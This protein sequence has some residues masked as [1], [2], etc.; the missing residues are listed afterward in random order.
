MKNLKNLA[1]I[2]PINLFKDNYSYLITHNSQNQGILIDP[3]DPEKIIEFLEDFKT[4]KISHVLYTHKHWDHSGQSLKM[5]NFL[6]KR[7]KNEKIFFVS[8]LIDSEEI[9]FVNLKLEG[10]QGELKVS[11][12]FEIFYRLLPCHTKGHLMFNFKLFKYFGESGD[13]KESGFLAESESLKQSGNK[14]NSEKINNFGENKKQERILEEFNDFKN[15]QNILKDGNKVFFESN[16]FVFTG[17][18]LF[19]AGC[20]RFF[21]GDAKMMKNNFDEI[22]KLKND[23]LVFCGHEYTLNDLK[24]SKKIWGENNSYVNNFIDKLEKMESP[25]SIPSSVFLQKKINLFM[26]CHSED[27][28]KKFNTE[29]P[30]VVMKELRERKNKGVGI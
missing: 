1:R 16:N 24:W 28:K 8:S 29:D 14:G 2:Y 17:D 18:C 25:F 23:T 22:L 10:D 15:P 12:G 26:N 3:A 6:K 30:V 5:K 21:E 9:D 11:D 20:G 7:D 13:F 4:T 19:L 27:L